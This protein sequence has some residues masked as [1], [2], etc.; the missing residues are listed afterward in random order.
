MRCHMAPRS[1]ILA[2]PLKPLRLAR[3]GLVDRGGNPRAPS[4]CFPPALFA[5]QFLPNFPTKASRLS[6]LWCRSHCLA[7]QFRVKAQ[8]IR[9]GDRRVDLFAAVLGEGVAQEV[10]MG[11][12]DAQLH[13]EF[14]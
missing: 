5:A 4:T 13:E 7:R 2:R 12:E 10:G 3:S 1:P 8:A 11:R 9:T 6:G 14:L